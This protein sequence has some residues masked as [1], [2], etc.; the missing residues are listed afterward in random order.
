MR[1]GSFEK[2]RFL[3]CLVSVQAMGAAAVWERVSTAGSAG[4]LGCVVCRRPQ[5]EFSGLCLHSHAPLY[6]RCL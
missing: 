1:K 3:I 6:P 2:P 5:P 4:G